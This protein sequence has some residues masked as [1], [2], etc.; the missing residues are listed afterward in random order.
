[1]GHHAPPNCTGT[2]WSTSSLPALRHLTQR[3]PSLSSDGPP[4]HGPPAR[5]GMGRVPKPSH[6]K[7]PSSWVESAPVGR[8]R[9]LRT[10]AAAT[11]SLAGIIRCFLSQSRV[12]PWSSF[13]TIATAR[14]AANNGRDV[15]ATVNGPSFTSRRSALISSPASLHLLT[16]G[17]TCV[18]LVQSF[19]SPSR[20]LSQ[21]INSGSPQASVIAAINAAG[22][23][24]RSPCAMRSRPVSSKRA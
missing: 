24:T 2:I 7:H 17:I 4:Y 5:V 3:Q 18:P 19:S 15:S 13:F 16:R 10:K 22:G 21:T 9:H 1:M 6:D 12:L 11:S 8:H 14:D 23:C 20:N